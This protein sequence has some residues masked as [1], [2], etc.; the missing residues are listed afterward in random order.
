MVSDPIAVQFWFWAIIEAE[1]TADKVYSVLT[2]YLFRV[3]SGGVSEGSFSNNNTPQISRNFT[4]YPTRQAQSSNYLTGSVSGF[5][6]SIKNKAYSDNIGQSEKLME[7]S[8]G[9]NPLFLLDPKGHFLRIHTAEAISLSIDHKSPAMPQTLTFPWIEVD[10][11][12]GIALISAPGG[13]FYPADQVIFTT[14]HLD[15]ETGELIW[16]VPEGYADGSVLSIRDGELMQS[17][18]GSFVAAALRIDPDTGELVA[19]PGG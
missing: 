2:S 15:W 16:T 4:R 12:E 17:T 11:T 19:T 6:G 3:G 13:D 18:E 1:E 5:I 10:S 8:T 9:D 7:L 14:V